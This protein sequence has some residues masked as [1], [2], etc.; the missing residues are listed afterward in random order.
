Q[1]L[2]SEPPPSFSP[3]QPSRTPLASLPESYRLLLP[4][5]PFR[6]DYVF[7]SSSFRPPHLLELR[8]R[9]RGPRRTCLGAGCTCTLQLVVQSMESGCSISRSPSPSSLSAR[10]LCPSTSF[11]FGNFAQVVPQASPTSDADSSPSNFLFLGTDR[12]G[13]RVTECKLSNIQAPD[14]PYI[15]RSSS[16]R[17][18]PVQD[19]LLTTNSVE[20]KEI[21][22]SGG[23]WVDVVKDLKGALTNVGSCRTTGTSPLNGCLTVR[24]GV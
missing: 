23:P 20:R 1:S 8:S 2:L 13:A 5:S 10:Y 18:M 9:D 3:Y 16:V 11:P 7:H 24:R 21:G 12:G 4:I 19:G 17:S 6:H 14:Y 22:S 15:S